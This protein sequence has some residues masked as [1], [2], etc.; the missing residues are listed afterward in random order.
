MDIPVIITTHLEPTHRLVRGGGQ[1]WDGVSEHVA[2][3]MARRPRLE[4][5]S[6]RPVNFSFCLRV[7]PQI[8]IAY[9]KA[10]WVFDRYAD[11]I[12]QLREAGDTVGLHVHTWR[13]V[14]R[15]FR[16]GWV[17]DFEDADWIAHCLSMGIEAF[18]ARMG[19][20][21]TTMSFGDNFMHDCALPIM[22]AAGIRADYSMDPGLNTTTG[23]A[24]GERLVGRIPDYSATPRAPFKP[25]A[26]DFR[27]PGPTNYGFWEVPVSSGVVGRKRDG[28]ERR[29]KLLLGTNPEWV[30]AICTQ[31]LAQPNPYILAESRTDV[32]THPKTRARF[33]E[34]LDHLEAL[35][36]RHG[37]EFLGLDA[38]CDRLDAGDW[39]AAA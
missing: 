28:S 30:S 19:A 29:T 31:A 18:R 3:L 34:A 23:L 11:E 25:S 8:E 4:D 20:A 15:F 32:L 37:M 2:A 24:K 21:P 6:G 22:Q 7:D 12:A 27:Q 26:T 33:F 5:A 35:A 9:G 17:A 38:F 16:D 13:P 14:R 10:D 39:P 36:P 1:D